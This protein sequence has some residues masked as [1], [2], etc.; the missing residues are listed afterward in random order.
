MIVYI[1]PGLAQSQEPEPSDRGRSGSFGGPDA[2]SNR[3]ESDRQVADP[4]FD[5]DF[6]THYW[7]WK[8]V[9]REKYGFTYGAEYNTAFQ[10]ATG[11]LPGADN[12]AASGSSSSIVHLSCIFSVVG[13]YPGKAMKIR[14][15][16]LQSLM[17][18]FGSNP[19][20]CSPRE[21]QPC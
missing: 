4:L 6:L 2:V 19:D 12:K 7:E 5:T 18:F 3:I 21:S 1:Q 11:R 8:D 15:L 9:L 14:Q 20:L 13:V 16:L 17:I 10:A